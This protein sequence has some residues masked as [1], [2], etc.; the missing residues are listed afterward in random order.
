M[1]IIGYSERGA[2]NA[3]FYNIAYNE[4]YAAM[5]KFLS[6]ARIEKTYKDYTFYS[7]FSLSEYGCPDLIIIAD[8]KDIIFI[9]AKVSCGKKYDINTQKEH[10]NKYLKGNQKNKSG[11]ASNIFFQLRLK[12]LLFKYKVKGLNF[13]EEYDITPLLYINKRNKKIELKVGANFA[14]VKLFNKLKMCE[15]AYYIAI[16]PECDNYFEPIVKKEFG[17]EI[18]YITW[19]SIFK[20]KELFYDSLRETIFFN[21]NDKRSQLLNKVFK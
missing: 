16:I 2:M 14:V 12:D 5:R 3:L 18:H 19:E 21:Q 15:N 6:L 7:E 11:F 17:I 10:H 1:N 13:N 4:D 20:S 8:N 9:E